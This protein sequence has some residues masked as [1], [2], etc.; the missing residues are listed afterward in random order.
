MLLYACS[1]NTGKLVEF[2][3]VLQQSPVANLEIIPLPGLKNIEPPA[4]TGSTFEENAAL[5]AI[6][7]SQFSNDLV[8]ADDS[9]L[10]VDALGG[11]P[12]IYSARFAGLHATDEENNAFL[13]RRLE[14][15]LN[16]HA[17]F[18]CAIALAQ[19]G[20][21]FTAVQ[22]T[23]EGEILEA[24]QGSAGFGYD[25]LFFYPPL[26]KAFAELSP[27]AKFAVSHRGNAVHA[28]LH[29][30]ALHERLTASGR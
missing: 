21:L 8:L 2:S 17:R 12:G 24:P 1:T 27:E 10:V 9:G 23:V 29:S 15:G 5:K 30:A 14:P 16:R 11:E 6:Y 26:G 19:A 18:V 4:E 22:G 28:L 7:Y 3:L 20:H 13:L 25:P